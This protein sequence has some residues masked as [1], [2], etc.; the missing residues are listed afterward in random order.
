[1][2]VVG[3]L[4]ALVAAKLEVVWKLEDAS[5]VLR[6]QDERIHRLQNE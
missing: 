3:L 5:E 4:K 2:N 1:M 6:M